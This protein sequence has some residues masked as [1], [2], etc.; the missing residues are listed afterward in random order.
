[1]SLAAS[2]NDKIIELNADSSAF[3]FLLLTCCSKALLINY[4]HFM[5]VQ[6][7]YTNARLEVITVALLTIQIFPTITPC[8]LVY[9]YR[10]FEDL[11]LQRQTALGGVD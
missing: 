5:A 3:N 2:I 6:I 1:M 4:L 7:T 9:R 10:H 8:F 11:Y